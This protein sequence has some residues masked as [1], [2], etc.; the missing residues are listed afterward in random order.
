MVDPTSV[1]V[2]EAAAVHPTYADLLAWYEL[3]T[4]RPA[5]VVRDAGGVLRFRPDTV[6]LRLYDAKAVDLNALAVDHA[7]GRIATGDYAAFVAGLGYSLS[8]FSELSQFA[9][10]IWP[11]E[12]TP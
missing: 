10:Q 6:V 3:V 1:T 2:A 4:G 5:R 7:R 12:P 11:E 8:G 9:D